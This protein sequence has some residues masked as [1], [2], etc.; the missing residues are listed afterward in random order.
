MIAKYIQNMPYVP[1]TAV[2]SVV[3]C[4]VSSK[5]K[6]LTIDFITVPSVLKKSVAAGLKYPVGQLY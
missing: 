1:I 4:C 6:P 2:E 3:T 5:V